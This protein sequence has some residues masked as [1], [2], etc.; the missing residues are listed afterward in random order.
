MI[1]YFRDLS[2]TQ[3][4]SF[5]Q[6]IQPH[7]KCFTNYLIIDHSQ[8]VEEV[9]TALMWPVIVEPF[10]NTYNI[11]CETLCISSFIIHNSLYYGRQNT[12]LQSLTVVK[13]FTPL[14]NST[15]SHHSCS[16]RPCTWLSMQGETQIMQHILAAGRPSSAAAVE[17]VVG[18]APE[19][20]TQG[21][22]GKDTGCVPIL[23]PFVHLHTPCHGLPPAK[24]RPIQWF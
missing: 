6:H 3:Y 9:I 18:W 24:T 23:Y 1:S 13:T 12:R 5:S 8:S 7:T 15:V 2:H 17:V 11:V 19:W 4:F 14:I 22:R 20:C 21:R 16:F 10:L